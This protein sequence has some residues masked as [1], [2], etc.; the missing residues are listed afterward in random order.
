[1]ASWC[2]QFD[3]KSIDDIYALSALYRP[4]PM[5]FI[6]DYIKRKKGLTKIKYAHP[7]LQQVCGDTYGIMIYQEQVMQAAQVLAGYTLG[8]ADLLRRAMGKKDKEKMAKEREKFVEGCKKLNNIDER[9]ANE[10]FDLLEKFAGY[11]F[12]K[13]HS[14]AYGWLTYQT[15]FLKANYPVEFMAAV[16]SNEINNTDKISIFVGECQRMGIEILPPDVNCSGLTFLPEQQEA[17]VSNCRENGEMDAAEASK[18]PLLRGIRYG[19]AAIK[20]VGQAAME[21]AI[22]DREKNGLFKSLEDFC[23][24]L[25]SRKINK[26]VIES[27]VKCGAFDFTGVE[28]AALFAEIDAA[29]LASASAHRDRASGQVSLF[30]ALTETAPAPKRSQAS[31]VPWS[32]AEKLAFEKELLGFYV[33]GHPLDEYRSVLESGL[34]VAIS[35]LGEQEDKST[36]QVAGALTV[37]E[38]KFTKKDGKPFAIV[39]LEDFTGTVEVMIWNDAFSKYATHLEQGRAVAITGRLDRREESPRIVASEIK[40][41]KPAPNGAS[42]PVVLSFQRDRTTENDLIEVRNA[43][44]QSPGAS[45]VQ[46]E[47]VNGDGMRLRMKLGQEFSVNLSPELREKL[48]PWLRK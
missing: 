37:V 35:A 5:E 20:N 23:G 15:A 42:K 24:R 11:G 7:L 1:M 48:L 4:G 41:L 3:F 47:F 14:A 13:S 22:Q 30:D 26:K 19:L 16:M 39:T 6:P 46:I 28:R 2:R 17:A 21:A 9:K 12:N 45:P 44:G 33:T 10:I 8:G 36:V 34:Y 40:P 32:K 25:D 27:L 43:I 31:V 18:P 29:L 38:K